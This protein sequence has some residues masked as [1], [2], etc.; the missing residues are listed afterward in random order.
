MRT[1]LPNHFIYEFRHSFLALST[2][3]V[4]IVGAVVAL[5]VSDHVASNLPTIPRYY[6]GILYESVGI[7][8]FDF[9]AWDVYG[10]PLTGVAFSVS[11]TP[12]SGGP[13]FMNRSGVTSEDGSLDLAIALVNGSYNASVRAGPQFPPWQTSYWWNDPNNGSVSFGALPAGAFLRLLTP[14]VN[15]VNLPVGFAGETALRIHFPTWSVSCPLGCPAY[16]AIVNL[17][18]GVAPVALA[19]SNMTPL[20]ILASST[21]TLPLGLAPSSISYWDEVQ[22]E[23][24]SPSGALLALSANVSA[25]AL[26][27]Q[28]MEGLPSNLAF[29]WLLPLDLSFV[30]PL[31]AIITSFAVYARDRVSGALD[32]TLVQPITRAGLAASRFLAATASVLVGLAVTILLTD[33]LVRSYVGYY[34]YPVELAAKFVGFTVAA[35]FFAGLVFL[36]SHLARSEVATIAVPLSVYGGFLLLAVSNDVSGWNVLLSPALSWGPFTSAFL[37]APFLDG[38]RNPPPF[39]VQLAC[40]VLTSAAW[41]LAPLLTLFLQIRRRD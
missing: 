37:G 35:V 20:G 21:E 10:T 3:V 14:Y 36:V 9:N 17:S 27:P 23:V 24:F 19:E 31:V 40:L 25:W 7:F 4:V 22:V 6:S 34:A 8:H 1:R 38:V 30:V 5:D 12:A 29:Q 41:V 39:G 15:A 13:P 16:Y 26:T 2:A 33:A 32:A 28:S 18:N 11:V